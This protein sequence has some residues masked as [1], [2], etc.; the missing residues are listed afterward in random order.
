MMLFFMIAS[1]FI[2]GGFSS[3][4]LWDII[5][6][7]TGISF[8]AGSVFSDWFIPCLSI[9]YILFPVLF[10]F[11]RWLFKKNIALILFLLVLPILAIIPL[12]SFNYTLFFPRIPMVFLGIMTFLSEQEENRNKL[13]IILFYCT[14]LTCTQLYKGAHLAVPAI[15]LFFSYSNV[16]PFLSLFS[17][18]GK[19]SLEIYLA[20]CLLVFNFDLSNRYFFN[21]FIV[22]VVIIIAST[23]LY[24]SHTYF[25]EIA[26]R[27]R[28]GN[29][30]TDE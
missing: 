23:L 30:K 7:A 10:Y 1:F 2:K 4:F 13:L 17:F 29:S 24:Y 12:T 22:L 9:I 27:L 14:L 15:I 28:K 8:W 25:W 19:H 16:H 5:K 18:L 3:M 26:T 21:L 6:H 11:T 20:Q